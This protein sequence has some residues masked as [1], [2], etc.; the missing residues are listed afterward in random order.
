[1]GAILADPT[2]NLLINSGVAGI[3]AAFA[4]VQTREF[5]KAIRHG[6]EANDAALVKQGEQYLTYMKEQRDAF[7]SA[8]T[9]IV[10][11]ISKL[12][13]VISAMNELLIRHDVNAEAAIRQLTQKQGW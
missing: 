1:L 11:E 8:L 7:T 10:F 9:G 4:V 3:F 6:R 12:A 2:L 5:L 13:T